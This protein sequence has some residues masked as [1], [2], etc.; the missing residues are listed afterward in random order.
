MLKAKYYSSASLSLSLRRWRRPL[1]LAALASAALVLSVPGDANAHIRL[2]EPASWVVEGD[3]GDPQKEAPCGG[4]NVTETGDV[5]TFRAGETI[6]VRWQ[7]TVGHSGH[8]RISLARDRADLIDPVVETSNGDGVSGNSISAEIMNPVAYPVLK[9]GLFAR[10]TVSGPQAAPFETTVTLPDEE[11]DDCTLQVEQ[12]MSKHGPGYFYHHCA[13][14]RIVAADAEL[15]AGVGGSAA[16]SA[17]GAAPAS[18]PGG[19]SAGA[20]GTASATAGAGGAPAT[21]PSDSDDD[22]SDDS[23]S[24]DGGCSINGN[25]RQL[26]RAALSALTLVGA[27]AMWR[28]RRWHR[29]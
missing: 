10:D 15:P 6:T 4:T 21:R 14:V 27:V 12:F 2:L 22:V 13:N 29:R 25:P 11:C 26:T 3:L 24:D 19:A 7:E 28:R 8:F 18:A 5:T 23:S 20:A 9:D 16:T 17:G 1:G